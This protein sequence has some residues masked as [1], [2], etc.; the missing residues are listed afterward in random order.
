[1]DPPAFGRL[2][3]LLSAATLAGVGF[4]GLA[5]AGI[6]RVAASETEEATSVTVRGTVQLAVMGNAALL[7]ATAG[8][9]QII[10][11]SGFETAAFAGLLTVLL[12]I[13]LLGALARGLGQIVLGIQVEQ[14]I[15]PMMQAL[16]V[17][18][19]AM[20]GRPSSLAMLMT[21][22]AAGTL[23]LVVLLA[24]PVAASAR[25]RGRPVP[26]ESR[27]E[28]LGE[29]APVVANALVWR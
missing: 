27:R 19:C 28:I 18:A 4:A 24:R 17:A 21:A 5:T 8:V 23:P 12:W 29:A 22:Q 13:G 14:V 3:L 11:I 25:L 20:A 15:V 2:L 6:R 1:L 10:G 26:P 9:Y 16:A 7:L